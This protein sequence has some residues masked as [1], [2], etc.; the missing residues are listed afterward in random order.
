MLRVVPRVWHNRGRAGLEGSETPLKAAHFAIIAA[1]ALVST[2]GLSRAAAPE[3]GPGTETVAPQPDFSG[4]LDGLR[5]DAVAAGIKT[6]TLDRAL[7]G[8]Q[9]L[10]RV[11]QLDR[12]Q[13]EFTQTFADY[14]TARVTP[15]R[16]ALG[17]AKVAEHADA[18]AAVAKT[19]GVQARFIAAI[20]GMETNY[21]RFT[22]GFPVIASLATLAF[23]T[24]RSSYFRRELIEALKILDQDHISLAELQGSWAGAMGQSQFMPSSYRAYARDFDGDGRRDIWGTPADV[25]A[26]IANYL[27]RHGWRDDHTWGR[28]VRLPAGFPARLSEL[29]PDR[30]PSTCARALRYHTRRLKLSEWQALGVRRTDGRDLPRRDLEASLVQP[31]GPSGPS[32][33]TYAN[34]RAI[35]RYN[36]SNFYAIAVGRL[37]DLIAQ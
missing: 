14:L 22:G 23:D 10:S 31:D 30:P 19:Y 36:C 26:S 28:Q 37:S 18:L 6:A 4:W 5:R 13:P 34:F 2:G 16:I 32:Y 12:N 7:E 24:R 11:V 20:W 25:F 8:L 17:R 1:I 29:K 33:L 21:G 15:A 3:P 27:A 35:L 9:P